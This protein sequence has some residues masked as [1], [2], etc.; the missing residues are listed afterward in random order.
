[1]TV[2]KQLGVRPGAILDC[3]DAAVYAAAIWEIYPLVRDYIAAG[4]TLFDY[5]YQLRRSP[6]PDEWF[7]KAFRCWKAFNGR[8]ETL[9][10]T[11]PLVL[12]VDV[13]GYYEH[14][15]HRRRH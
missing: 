9:L 1:V 5:A 7:V 2:P 11:Y 15:D 12:L 3:E 13:A 10:A 8:S 14:I 6:A 4:P